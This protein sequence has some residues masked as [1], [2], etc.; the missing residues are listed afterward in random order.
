MQIAL[1]APDAKFGYDRNTISRTFARCQPQL[2]TWTCFVVVLC[3]NRKRLSLSLS[4]SLCLCISFASRR[5]NGVRQRYPICRPR[6]IRF[7]PASLPTCFPPS[8]RS[9]WWSSSLLVFNFH[10][11]SFRVAISSNWKVE[12]KV[13]ICVDFDHRYR[14]SVKKVTFNFESLGKQFR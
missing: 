13:R 2:S 12:S 6:S 14:D 10:R 11:V 3:W 8:F 1:S 7:L 5:N 4:L 9:R